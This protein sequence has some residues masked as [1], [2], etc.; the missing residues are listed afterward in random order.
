M[1][2]A[3][4]AKKYKKIEEKMM[5]LGPEMVAVVHRFHVAR[6]TPQERKYNLVKRIRE[7]V[8]W[9]KGKRERERE[10]ACHLKGENKGDEDVGN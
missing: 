4:D 1:D 10:R 9:L 6:V 5:R 3:S 7:E 2:Q 8:Y